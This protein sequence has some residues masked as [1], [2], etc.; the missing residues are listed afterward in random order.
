MHAEIARGSLT[1][2]GVNE[3][4][5]TMVHFLGQRTSFHA[6]YACTEGISTLNFCSSRDVKA[7]LRQVGKNESGNL[8]NNNNAPNLAQFLCNCSLQRNVVTSTIILLHLFLEFM[9]TATLTG[10]RY[11]YRTV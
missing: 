5:P 1:P 2:V 3:Y 10:I 6:S 8:F 9:V 11:S 7:V 4:P